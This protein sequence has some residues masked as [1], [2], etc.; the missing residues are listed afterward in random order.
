[1]HAVVRHY[2]GKRAKE[3]PGLL[4]QHKAEVDALFHSIKGFVSYAAAETES[5]SFTMTVCETKA[6]AD[7]SVVKAR[8]WVMKNV[9][10]LGAPTVAEGAVTL[11]IR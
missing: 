10:G 1:M 3:L 11:H 8:D 2:S 6:G 7:E 5:G 9:A 4:K